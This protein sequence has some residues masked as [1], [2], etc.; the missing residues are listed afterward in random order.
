MVVTIT[1]DHEARK[2]SYELIAEAFDLAAAAPLE[3]ATSVGCRRWR[4]DLLTGFPG[5]IGRRLV[6]RLLE[7]KGVNVVA[8]VEPRMLEA[9]TAAA[10]EIDAERVEVLAGDIS[11]RRLA[12]DDADWD[13]L[14]KEVRRVYHLAAI[15]DL[16]VPIEAR[17]ARER[18]RHRQ[19]ARAVRGREEARA[20]GLREHRL[21]G[22]ACARGV[23]YEHEL[24]MGQDFKNHYESTKFQAEVWVREE[25]A[26]VPTTILRPAIVVG[27]SQHRRDPEVRRPLLHPARHLRDRSARAGRWCSSAA[28]TP[29]STWCRWTTWWRRSPPRRRCPRRRA[30]PSTWWTPSRSPPASS[31]ARWPSTTARPPPKGRI[32]PAL[33]ETSLRAP[34]GRRRASATPRG[35]RSPTS[36]TRWSSTPAARSTCWARRG[37]RRRSFTDYVE[38]DGALLP[39][40]RGRPRVRG[41]AVIAVVTGASSGIGEAT[42][43]RLAREPGAKLVLVARREDRL[44]KLA[45]ELSATLRGGR[46]DRRRRAR[47]RCSTTCARRTGG[48]TCW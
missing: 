42:A 23:V 21:R 25:M 16:A 6:A 48:S 7:E 31:R 19:R 12:L 22:R 13:R 15:Y 4:L 3:H 2:R 30:R 46:P 34:R 32:P 43:R 36:T 17:P 41:Q 35:S 11:E 45:D 28:P 38:R 40:A 24:V 14:T 5:F 1:F 9:A 20:A 26:D 27:D 8:L 33:V 18:G 29:A 39:R 47:A 44:R 10:A 37:S